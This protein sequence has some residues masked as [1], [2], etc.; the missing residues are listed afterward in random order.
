MIGGGAVAGASGALMIAYVPPRGEER[1]FDDVANLVLGGML[2]LAGAIL[3]GTSYFIS[4]DDEAMDPLEL[5]TPSTPPASNGSSN[6]RAARARGDHEPVEDR[7]VLHIRLAA[8][9][10]RCDAA[11]VMMKKLGSLDEKR[12]SELVSGDEHVARCAANSASLHPSS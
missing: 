11:D 12:A 6:R 1:D 7:L 5:Q 2:V 4:P 8:R 10:N 3:V 9:A